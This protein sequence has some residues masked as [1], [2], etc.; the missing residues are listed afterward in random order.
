MLGNTAQ[1]VTSESSCLNKGLSGPSELPTHG[2][3]LIQ[4]LP[5]LIGHPQRLRRLDG[6]LQLARP[7]LEI[8][9]LLFLQKLLESLGELGFE[10]KV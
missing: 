10:I 7:H 5:L 9:Y 1:K 4:N 8:G 6:P 3:N 2:I